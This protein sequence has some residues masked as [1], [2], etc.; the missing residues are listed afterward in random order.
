MKKALKP[1]ETV[2]SEVI[3]LT[4]KG[5]GLHRMVLVDLPGIISVSSYTLK[6]GRKMA[7]LA[8]AIILI[9]IGK[10]SFVR[11][12]PH[13]ARLNKHG[14][15]SSSLLLSSSAKEHMP[16]YIQPTDGDKR[17]DAEDEGSSDRHGGYVHEEP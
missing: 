17:N 15:T 3:S 16:P 5:P 12:R 2:S 8:P 4:V 7:S 1:G 11:C 13:K 6:Y 10:Y 14:R 9:Y